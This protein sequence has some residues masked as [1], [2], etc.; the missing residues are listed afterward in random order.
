MLSAALA[1]DRARIAE[2]DNQI[3]DLKRSLA[4][5]RLEKSGVQKRLDA[6][7][8]T[9]LTLPNEIVA[10]IFIRFLP[11]CPSC[12]PLSGSLSP[13]RLTQICRR[14]REIALGTPALWRAVSLDDRHFDGDLV[15]MW[16]TLDGRMPLLRHFELWLFRPP[17][18]ALVIG[19]APLLRTANLDYRAVPNVVLPWTQL[20]HLILRFISIGNCVPVLQQTPNLV[21]CDLRLY[22]W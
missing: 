18:N 13:T 21:Y 1:A 4:A 5:L 6:Y 2:F 3:Q 10:E 22:S 15:Q 20:T 14:W 9:V 7:K 12:P 8:Y 11:I 16:F 19:D 17:Q